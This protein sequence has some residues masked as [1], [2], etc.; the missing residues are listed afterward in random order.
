MSKEDGRMSI[1]PIKGKGAITFED[2][3]YGTRT[4][5]VHNEEHDPSH[6]CDRKHLDANNRLDLDEDPRLTSFR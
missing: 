2:G 1:T 6:D 3:D 5:P 4:V